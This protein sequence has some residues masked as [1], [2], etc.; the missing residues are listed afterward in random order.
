M[1]IFLSGGNTGFFLGPVVA[2][3]LGSV[4]GLQ[5]MLLLLPLGLA[6]A[7]IL[8]KTNIGRG[9]SKQTVP[10][11]G[12]PAKKRLLGLLAGITALRSVAVQSA[13]TFLPLYFVAKGYSLLLATAIASIWLGVG[14]L[15]QLGG[16]SISDRIGKRPVIAGSLLL[17]A[18]LFYGF[19][20]TTGPIS[21]IL[22]A[23]SGAALY[24]SW[25]V[26][27]VMSSEA[28]P[29]N[30]GAVSGFMLGFSVGVGG[31]TALGFGAVADILGLG[32]AFYIV[33]AFALVGGFLALILPGKIASV[34]YLT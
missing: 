6:V 4:F 29:D 19:L 33:T 31:V 18:A 12:Y 20:L 16:G 21:L 32:A 17:G 3:A 8:F 10:R 25:S 23:L 22:L 11:Y 9:E 5:G 15:G 34:T 28:A 13:T 24:A 7:V 26:I 2:G 30:F 1:G 14:V 27:V